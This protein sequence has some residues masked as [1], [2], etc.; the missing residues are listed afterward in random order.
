MTIVDSNIS[1]IK[2]FLYQIVVK[3]VDENAKQWLN[4]KIALLKDAF[5]AQNF[6][7]AFTSA[8]RFV[9]KKNLAVSQ[10]ELAQADRLREGFKPEDW[11]IDRAVRVLLVLYIPTQNAENHFTVLDKVFQTAEVNELVALYSSLPLLPF[12]EYYINRCAEGVRTNI[13]PVFEATALNN[14]FPADYLDE[15]AW[16]QL[17]LKA[18]FTGKLVYKIQGIQKR[19]NLALAQICSDY[20]HERWAAGRKITP[21]LWMPIAHFVD[22]KIIKDLERLK[23][24]TDILQQQALVLV[25]LESQNQG[26]KKLLEG[27]ELLEEEAKRSVFS[28]ESISKQW[29]TEND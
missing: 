18:I 12:P 21:E 20:A 3:Q 24:S 15:N 16:N 27:L 7:I 1:A 2:D 8:P 28:W 5:S 22:D 9:G 6:Y 23:S 13:A 26:A 4:Q 19:A 14:P 25:C 17:F 10:E 29:H 11:T